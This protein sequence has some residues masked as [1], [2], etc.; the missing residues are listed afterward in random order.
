MATPGPGSRTLDNPTGVS[1]QGEL[2][3]KPLALGATLLTPLCWQT[4][5]GPYLFRPWDTPPVLIPS[6]PALE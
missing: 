5:G 2:P 6:T 4:R 1:Q 3:P